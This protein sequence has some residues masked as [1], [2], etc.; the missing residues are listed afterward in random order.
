MLLPQSLSGAEG[1]F[2]GDPS[3][4]SGT[5]PLQHIRISTEATLARLQLSLEAI[6][7]APQIGNHWA[8]SPSL[9]TLSLPYMQVAL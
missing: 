7:A 1:L 4:G 2:L 5:S 8:H 9:R 6:C 3:P